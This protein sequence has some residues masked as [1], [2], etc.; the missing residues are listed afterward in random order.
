MAKKRKE[1]E[2]KGMSNTF[3]SALTAFLPMAVGGLFGGIEG[4]VA[5]GEGAQ[6]AQAAQSQISMD[7]AKL[8]LEQ[9]ALDKST[10]LKERELDIKVQGLIQDRAIAE[11]K[12]VSETGK[13][14]KLGGEETKQLNFVQMGQTA[15]AGMQA[16]IDDDVNKFSLVGDNEYTLNLRNF[17]EAMGRMQSGGAINKDEE[18]R[19][20]AMAPTSLDSDEIVKSK[21]AVLN[22]ELSRRFENITGEPSKLGAVSKQS[23]AFKEI[24]SNHTLEELMAAR[25]ARRGQ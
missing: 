4:A 25:A 10:E 12:Q 13:K 17:S 20:L 24:A 19:F 21:M 14:R 9:E 5:A 18:V 6:K 8:S 3:Q 11:Q 22:E 23:E 2:D 7:Q 1:N 16:A 15:L